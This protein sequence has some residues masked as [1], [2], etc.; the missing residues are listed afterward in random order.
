M[1]EELRIG[2]VDGD[3]KAIYIYPLNDDGIYCVNKKYKFI[4]GEERGLKIM[5]KKF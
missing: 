2:I 3:N 4:R 5:I 1:S